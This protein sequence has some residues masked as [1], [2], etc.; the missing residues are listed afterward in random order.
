MPV[1]S[2][3]LLRTK[4]SDVVENPDLINRE[5]VFGNVEKSIYVKDVEGN[6]IEFTRVEDSE[7]SEN[8]TW[9]AAKIIAEMLGQG[10]VV[11]YAFGEEVVG[12]I[13]GINTTF[14]TQEKFA[15]ST[16]EIFLNGLRLEEGSQ[17]DY[18]VNDDQEFTLNYA[19]YSGDYIRVNYFRKHGV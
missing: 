15:D 3:I 2:K 14:S 5:I 1:F 11:H 4:V 17:D 18:V 9:S 16:L 12:I 13:D 19:P 10:G 8:N 6:L 7:N